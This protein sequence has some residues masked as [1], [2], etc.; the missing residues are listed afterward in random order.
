M[1]VHDT[2]VTFYEVHLVN[3]DKK[4][5][6]SPA[7]PREKIFFLIFYAWGIGNFKPCQIFTISLHEGIW[8]IAKSKGL[9][10]LC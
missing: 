8:G 4:H 7:A 6:E 1:Y 3:T 5:F 10:N 9:K 2:Y